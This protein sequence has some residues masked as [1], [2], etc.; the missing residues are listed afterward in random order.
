MFIEIIERGIADQD[1]PRLD[2]A[3]KMKLSFH[4]LEHELRLKRSR[5]RR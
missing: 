5:D 1:G 3:H 2:L 4:G